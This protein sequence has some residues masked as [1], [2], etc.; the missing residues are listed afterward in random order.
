M[1]F[2]FMPHFSFKKYS[3]A[4]AFLL[5]ATLTLHAQTFSVKGHVLSKSDTV[6]LIGAIVKLADA[7]DTT[8]AQAV[9][10]DID[11]NFTFTNV[12]SGHYRITGVYISYKTYVKMITVADKD[13]N[14]G[15]IAMESNASL[16]KSVTVEAEQQ[17]AEQKGDTTQFNAGA[18]KTNPDATAEDLVKKM[19]GVTSDGTTVKVNGEEVKKVMIDGKPFFGDDPTAALRNLPADVVD[20]VQIYDKASD[21]AQFTGFKDGD[22]QK[23]LNIITKPGRNVGQFGKVY[24][25]YGTDDRYN[26]GLMLNSFDNKRRIS[27]IGMSNNINQQNFNISDIMSVMSNS[28]AQGGGMMGPG[29]PGTGAATNFMTGQ[30]SGVAQTHAAG[31]NYS[32][33]W[34]KKINVVGSY[35]FNRTDNTN[36]SGIVR[37]YF[38]DDHLRYNQTS[39]S[40]TKNLNH[41]VNFRFEYNIDTMNSITINPRLTFQQ[42]NAK[43]NLTGTNQLPDSALFLSQTNNR[44]SAL[45]TGY[46]FQNDLLLQHKFRKKGRTISFNLNTQIN[47]RMG[48]GS[49]Y[50]SSVYNDSLTT[51][52]L[53]DQQYTNANNTTTWGGNLSYTEPLSLNS[54]LMLTYRPSWTTSDADKETK[55]IDGNGEY[56]VMDT[57]LSNKYKNTYTSQRGGLSYRYNKEKI[58]FMA[59]A[60]VE[61]AVLSGDQT[62]P[63]TSKL[64]RTYTNVLPTAM[65]SY[66]FSKTKNINI[67]YR[68]NTQAP[69]V[70]QLQNVI[71]ISNPLLV[72]SGNAD[73]KQTYQNNLM[74]RLGL[75]NPNKA[76]NFFI[77]MGA[78]QTMNY[79]SNATYLLNAD[80]VLQGYRINRGSQLIKP[81]NLNNYY[82]FRSFGVYSFPL[83][84]IKSNLNIN[85]G[86]TYAHTPA[87]IN[88]VLN[89]S[90]NNA[91]SGGIYLSS[92]ISKEL[93]FSIAYNGSYNT[94][95][96]TLQAQSDNAYFTHTASLKVN[97]ILAKR[98]VFNTDVNQTYYSGLTQ[99]YNQDFILWN[100]YIG[101]KFL[102]DQSLE[103]KVSVYDILNQN[104]SISRTVTETYTEDSNTNV[105][106]RY[107][108]FTLTYTFKHFKAG[109][110][111]PEQIQMPHG[112]PPPGSMPP[113]GGMP[114]PPPPGN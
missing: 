80:T 50:S 70:T 98:I 105:L 7:A 45:N 56:T 18:Y 23:A 64:S 24:G 3:S 55:D 6:P 2:L 48:N 92:N 78:N 46:N 12:A 106:K 75:G 49:Y 68:T 10:A 41:K 60:D 103:A 20:K 32:D 26:S 76:T 101:Y 83:K 40:R 74:M 61:Q 43:S 15:T 97:Y 88:N 19:P 36:Q 72:K 67:M 94:V 28:G 77:F 91:V 27:V 25:G 57:A 89:Y 53:L 44:T 73:L 14:L 108:M 37:N 81:V 87:L 29:G 5:L 104:K 99:S 100:A 21:Q 31:I 111:E 85:A 82:S 39:D 33:S 63:L 30:Q 93:D 38:T 84:P 90:R 9:A 22:E 8:K 112:M 52:T 65:F 96:N 79:I 51:S 13:V 54:Q 86:Y 59:G 42:T 11:G 4:T 69:S 71:D 17:R 58:N 47:N 114:P 66:K 35:F 107:F 109:A 34:G 102:K 113:P 95:K 62:Y 1:K 110:K 16:L